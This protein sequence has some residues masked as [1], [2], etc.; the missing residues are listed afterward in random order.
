MSERVAQNFAIHPVE[1]VELDRLAE[2]V[3]GWRG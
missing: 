1:A 3:A 2:A